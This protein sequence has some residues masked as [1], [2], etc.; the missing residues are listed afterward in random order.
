MLL[1][2]DFNSLNTVLY[3]NLR[4][5]KEAFNRFVLA[6]DLGIQ[7]EN[8]EHPM[9]IP[10]EGPI[11]SGNVYHDDGASKKASLEIGDEDDDEII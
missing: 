7:T 11:S 5:E 6:N 1:L 3:I 2:Y 9:V 8:L 10:T 4:V